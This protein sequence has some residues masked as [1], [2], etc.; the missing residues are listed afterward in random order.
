M[1]GFLRSAGFNFRDN[2]TAK[3]FGEM[4]IGR[5]PARF[6]LVASISL[7][8]AAMLH[9]QKAAPKAPH[10]D[11]QQPGSGAQVHTG[12][13][14][15]VD[16]D[17]RLLNMLA[18]HEFT[19]LEGEL[20]DLPPWQAQFYRGILANRNNDLAKSVALLE[21]VVDQVSAGANPRRERVLRKSLAE[22]YLRQGDW[23]KAAEAYATLEARLGT[24][25]SSDEQDELEMAVKM[26]PLAKDHPTMTVDPCAPFIVSIAK[27]PLGLTDVPVFV[28]AHSQ[29]WM[30]DPTLPFNLIS[31]SHAREAGLKVSEES[32]TI[33]TLRGREIKVHAT[34]VPRF[35]VG[36][37]ITLHNMTAFVYEDKDYYFPETHYQVEGE[38]GY[39]VMEAMGSVTVSDSNR[40][41]VD[42]GEQV[43]AVEKTDR[44]NGGVRFFLDGDQ[45][46]L[47]L[48][49]SSE[50][51]PGRGNE[52]MFAIDAGG[53]QTYLTSRFYDEHTSDFNGQQLELFKLKGLPNMAPVP[54][55]TVETLPLAVGKTTVQ[56]HFMPVLTQ[57]IGAAALDDVYGV[58]GV[59]ALDQLGSYTFDY[60]TM[61]FSIRL[62]EARD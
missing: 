23:P 15:G 62:S 42:P 38:L 57:P 21:P 28:D 53:Q 29:T 31:R 44:A 17:T 30:L 13:G 46:I 6:A 25:M 19:R 20:D 4:P 8:A 12:T 45:V 14:T 32:V 33:H 61:Q 55:Y 22:D 51:G 16:T 34:V 40:L 54:S 50:F 11:S 35:T 47:A 26:T 10:R 59:D 2:G 39:P 43:S 52:R 1:N 37:Q 48:G 24:T 27:N 36:G 56:F 18:D 41:Y 9:A 58:L 49:G 60:R 5:L 7:A 3:R